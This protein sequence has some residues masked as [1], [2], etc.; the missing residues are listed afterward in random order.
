MFQIPSAAQI[1]KAENGADIKHVYQRTENTEHQYLLLLR[2]PQR[3]ALFPEFLHLHLLPVKNLGDLDAGKIL[4]QIGVDI[5]GTVLHFSVS[6]SGKLAENH[7][8]QH[9]KRHKAEDHQR[10]LIA[11]HEHRRKHADNHEYIFHEIDQQIGKHHGD[12]VGVVGH[13]GHKLAD[14]YRV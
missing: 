5:R 2:P 11:Q 1:Q 9:N 10:Q 13:A 3:V 12:R 6:A 14:G 7:R 8:K 4:G